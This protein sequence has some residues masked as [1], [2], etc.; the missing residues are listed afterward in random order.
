M[1]DDTNNKGYHTVIPEFITNIPDIG[2]QIEVAIQELIDNTSRT[3]KTLRNLKRTLP[4]SD[5]PN[6]PLKKKRTVKRT[7]KILKEPLK[8][9][10]AANKK[11]SLK[12]IKTKRD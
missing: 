12:L 9:R 1:A 3:S 11:K 10:G 2:E 5:T 8:E 4:E 7:T 6:P